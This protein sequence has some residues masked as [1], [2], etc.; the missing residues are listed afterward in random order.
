MVCIY[1]YLFIDLCLILNFFRAEVFIYHVCIP[2][3]KNREHSY[4]Q[5]AINGWM[6][7][8]LLIELPSLILS[9]YSMS[10]CLFTRLQYKPDGKIYPDKPWFLLLLHFS[11]NIWRCCKLQ[12][13]KLQKYS[14]MLYYL[15]LE[16]RYWDQV[17]YENKIYFI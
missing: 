14:W 8:Y 15:R 2:K 12:G 17:K 16:S 13:K 6:D 11:S 1:K 5:C 10:P 7:K 3:V 9:A 4:H